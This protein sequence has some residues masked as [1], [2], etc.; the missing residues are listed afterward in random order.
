D[1]DVKMLCQSLMVLEP[2]RVPPST[3]Q[4]QQWCP[5]SAVQQLHLQAS[6]RH[7]FFPPSTCHA[8]S[9]SHAEQVRCTPLV[10]QGIIEGRHAKGKS[11][12]GTHLF[13]HVTLGRGLSPITL[14]GVALL[15]IANVLVELL[16]W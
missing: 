14:W 10:C 4:H 9:P 13:V 3:V 2:P 1:I 6:N 7:L 12:W 16:A 8:V 15:L 11:A 5:L